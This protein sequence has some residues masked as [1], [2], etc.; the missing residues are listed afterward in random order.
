MLIDVHELELHRIEF[1]EK[2]RPAVIDLGPDI[3][4]I[5]SL[6][7]RGHAELVEEQ[8][9]AKR[10]KIQDIRLVGNLAAEVEISCA[11]CLEPVRH[12]VARNFDLLYRPEGIDGGTDEAA[13]NEAE[14]EIGYYSG[15]GMLLEDALREQVLLAL[16]MKAVC[17]EDCKGLCPH[18]GQDL[19]TG[20]CGCTPATDPRWQALEALKDKLQK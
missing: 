11:R 8:H 7:A 9:G 10:K 3:R 16:P 5:E 4:Q 1:D 20:A 18:C 2:F 15:D 14:T 12:A 17:R 6:T 13:V 19:N